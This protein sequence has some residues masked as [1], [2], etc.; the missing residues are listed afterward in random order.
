MVRV[1]AQEA[2]Q[3]PRDATEL[4]GRGLAALAT[5]TSEATLGVVRYYREEPSPL[6]RD[7]RRGWRSGK[8]DRVLEGDFDLLGEV[9]AAPARDRR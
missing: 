4:R 2:V 6:V 3:P 1:A 9:H 5:A 8:L 7:C